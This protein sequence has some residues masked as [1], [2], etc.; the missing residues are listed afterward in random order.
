MI[1]LWHEACETLEGNYAATNYIDPKFQSGLW[2]GPRSACSAR[3]KV[4]PRHNPEDFH[5]RQK[6]G[7]NAWIKNEDELP[8][9]PF[10][11]SAMYRRRLTIAEAA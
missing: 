4:W 9:T 1:A 2:A 8:G 11:H 3:T 5:T 7:M 10:T 6:R